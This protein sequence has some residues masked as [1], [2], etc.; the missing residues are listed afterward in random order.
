M[1]SYE[2]AKDVEE[3]KNF[4]RHHMR[5]LHINEDD[6]SNIVTSAEGHSIIKQNYQA[7]VH[8]TTCMND[9]LKDAPD[10]ITDQMM[11]AV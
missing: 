2:Y 3:Y 5:K 1:M 4:V 8:P 10:Y 6:I 9:I 11:E 7:D